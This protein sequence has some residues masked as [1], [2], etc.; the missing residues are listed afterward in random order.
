M[1]LKKTTADLPQDG[2][3]SESGTFFV[4]GRDLSLAGAFEAARS[5]T[6]PSGFVGL[7]VNPSWDFLAAPVLCASMPESDVDA[8]IK[9]MMKAFPG[10]APPA[11]DEIVQFPLFQGPNSVLLSEVFFVANSFLSNALEG[12]IDFIAGFAPA[13]GKALLEATHAFLQAPCQS[14]ALPQRLEELEETYRAVIFRELPL[15]LFARMDGPVPDHDSLMRWFEMVFRVG[16]HPDFD[17]FYANSGETLPALADELEELF[18]P[19]PE[20]EDDIHRILEDESTP[21]PSEAYAGACAS[22]VLRCLRGESR[23]EYTEF[24][25]VY[26][27]YL[28]TQKAEADARDPL[29]YG[30][31]PTSFRM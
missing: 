15:F 19:G 27:E 12:D 25:T 5:N 24:M 21:A 18:F 9:K 6:D 16:D 1:P 8:I 22:E 26:G 11:P 23:F 2:P 13:A 14:D 3:L 28:V 20:D 29:P 30:D 7:K 17:D 31:Y 10:E 4:A